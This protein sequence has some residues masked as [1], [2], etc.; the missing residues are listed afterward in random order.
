MPISG[1]KFVDVDGIR[2]RYFER[3][4][5]EAVVLVH[6]GAFG[7]TTGACCADDWDL[8]FDGL[9]QW[10]RVFAID[11]LGQGYTDNP[12]TDDDYT[13]HAAVQ[14]AYA[15]L[16]ALGIEGAHLVGHSRGG[17]L[18]CR[19]T[20]EHPELVKSCT[21]VDS[22]TCAPG[23]GRQRIRV[24]QYAETRA[25][26]RK[27]EMGGAKILLQRRSRH[28]CVDRRHGRNRQAAEIR[29]S[30][31]QD[32]RGRLPVDQ[33][34]AGNP[35]PEGGD[36]PDSANPR[37]SSARSCRSGA[38]TTR[39]CRSNRAMGLYRILAEKERRARWQVFNRSGHYSFRE[40][41]KRFNDVIR[42]FIQAP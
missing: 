3:G 42:S 32:E 41:P 4:S 24:R 1:A 23:I 19:L 16:H 28:R 10:F 35:D 37:A 26:R 12:R 7:S 13:M 30:G 31:P 22:N 8:N 15:T 21:I 36:V 17:Y 6:G 9:A 25:E 39:P 14:H 11:K 27:P 5:G 40:H 34:P 33:V 20:V 38:A 29:R 2:T 18:V